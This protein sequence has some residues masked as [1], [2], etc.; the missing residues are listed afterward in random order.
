MRP[1]VYSSITK[2]A[3]RL[4]GQEVRLARKE[5]RMSEAD[6]AARVGIARSTVQQIEK[7][8]PKVEI[9]LVFEAATITGVNLFGA[10][11]VT[12]RGQQERLT[13]KLA[14]LPQSVRRPKRSEVSDDF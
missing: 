11:L 3:L 5:R 4:L 13:D 1:R 7:G 8:D 6:L 9:G 14:L 10:D 2:E 12:L